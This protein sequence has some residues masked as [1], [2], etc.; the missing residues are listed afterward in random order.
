MAFIKEGT[1]VS[2]T[3]SYMRPSITST[4]TIEHIQM[5]ESKMLLKIYLN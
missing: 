5:Y 2:T 3:L 4:Q 1:L